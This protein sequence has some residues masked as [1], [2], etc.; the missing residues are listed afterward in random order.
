MKRGKGLLIILSGPSGVGKG[1]VREKVMVDPALNLAYSISMTTRAMRPGEENGR[2]YY[3]VSKEEFDKNIKSNNLL[4]WTEYVGNKYGTPKDKIDELRNQGKNVLLEID[5][6]GATNVIN[7]IPDVISIFVVPPT[8]DD[9]VS[10]LVHRG[11]ESE[12][13][14]NDRVNRAKKE[15]AL[16]DN[17]KYVVINDKLDNAVQKIKEIIVIEGNRWKRF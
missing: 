11:T 13:V 9:L 5:V 15:M 7:A 3:F 12:E 16:K 14:I 1:T 2:E 17:Y 6:T 10:R 8:I 4:E